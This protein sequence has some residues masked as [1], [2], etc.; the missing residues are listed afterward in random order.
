MKVMVC[1]RRHANLKL[2]FQKTLKPLDKVHLTA[3]S[4]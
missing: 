4:L 3:K 2:C 1:Y